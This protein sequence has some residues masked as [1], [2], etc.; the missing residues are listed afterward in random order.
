MSEKTE[1]ARLI[2]K[3]YELRRETKMR[4]ARDWML[5]FFPES[6][7]DIMQAVM[8]PQT[9]AY[10]RM[11]TS[12]WNMAAG[13]VN[14]GAIDEQMFVESEG[15]YFMVFAK[16]E[17]FLA[18]MRE[19]SGYPNMF[20][21]LEMLAMRQPGARERLVKSREAMMRWKPESK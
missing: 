1:S 2:L 8:N 21:N 18:E 6:A 5:T 16:I 12:Y 9:S 11:V 19:A 20:L 3:L 14:H 15:E 4:E 17:P 7:Q 10:Y 13:F